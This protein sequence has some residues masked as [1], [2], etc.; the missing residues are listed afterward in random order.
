[1]IQKISRFGS[2]VFALVFLI[3]CNEEN[4]KED[5]VASVSKNGSIETVVSV[6]HADSADILVT[7]HKVWVKNS[8]AREIIKRDTIPVLGDTVVSVSNNGNDVKQ[9]VKKD[10]EFYITVQ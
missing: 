9:T 4:D 10:Y 2:V 7:R 1:M 5:A 6:E 8:L 3:S